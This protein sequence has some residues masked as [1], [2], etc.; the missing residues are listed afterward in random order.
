M[1][2]YGFREKQGIGKALNARGF[3][4]SQ[5]DWDCG[6]SCLGVVLWQR[7]LHGICNVLVDAALP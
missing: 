6:A 7:L 2:I 1:I 5:D 3:Y 4:D